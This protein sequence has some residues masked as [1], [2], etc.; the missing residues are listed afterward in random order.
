MPNTQ[1]IETNHEYRSLPVATLV[2][3]PTNPRKPFDERTLAELAASFKAQGVSEP[4]LVR[5]LEATKYEVVIGA[6][7]LKAARLAELAS[8]P[9]LVVTL[10]DAGHRDAGGR[11]PATR[12]HSSAR[13]ISRF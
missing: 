10:S 5:P 7:R 1:P 13:R 2:E 12:G 8:V 3:S 4:L 11:E 6:R 9:V